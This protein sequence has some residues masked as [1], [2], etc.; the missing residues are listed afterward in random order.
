MIHINQH[1]YEEFFLLYAD[2]ELDAA[3]KL[4]VEQF[5]ANHPDL[6]AELDLLLGMRLTSEDNIIFTNKS[7]LYRKEENGIN[8]QNCEEYFL[9]YTDH[10]LS[11]AQQKEVETFVLQNPS[12][13]PGFT[14]IR[15]TKLE[16]E[17]LVFPEKQ[18]LY[19]KEEKPVFYL[20]WQRVAVAAVLIGLAILLWTVIPQ[21]P[22]KKLFANALKTVSTGLQTN[23]AKNTSEPVFSDQQNNKTNTNLPAAG[24]SAV[25]EIQNNRLTAANTIEHK[26]PVTENSI[27]ETVISKTLAQADPVLISHGNGYENLPQRTTRISGENTVM[28]VVD[29]DRIRSNEN[30]ETQTASVSDAQPVVYRELDTETADEKK[31]LLLGSLEINKDKLRGFFRKAGSIFRGKGKAEEEK[32]DATPNSSTRSLK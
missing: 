10:S 14:L 31:S 3:G 12:V 4:A 5:V 16:P 27:P 22:D 18:S 26:E 1:N 32:S 6:A 9:L 13:Q 20:Y 24:K 28:N 30:I 8:L 25:A 11:E 15:Q 19:R 29:K 23:A 7:I 17:T 21:Q 2:G